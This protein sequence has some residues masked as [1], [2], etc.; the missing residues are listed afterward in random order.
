MGTSDTNKLVK[1]APPLRGNTATITPANDYCLWLDAGL[2]AIIQ[3][4]KVIRNASACGGRTE[5]DEGRCF[6][7]INLP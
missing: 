5:C 7:P 6:H 2:A 3:Y 1:A 4:R